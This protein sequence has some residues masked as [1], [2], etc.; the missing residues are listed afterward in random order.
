MFEEEKRLINNI[1]YYLI[2][3]WLYTN[4]SKL[5]LEQFTDILEYWYSEKEWQ[6]NCD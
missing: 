2:P 6:S 3:E 4:K 1:S 5:T